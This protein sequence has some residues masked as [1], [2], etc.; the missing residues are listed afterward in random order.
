MKLTLDPD[1]FDACPQYNDWL[2]QQYIDQSGTLDILGFQPRPS[3]VLFSLSQDTYQAA[4]ADFQQQR[5]EELKQAIFYDFPSPI[6]HYFYRFENGYENELQRLHFLRDTWEAIID[7]LHATTIAECRFRC[8]PLA[9]PISFSHILSDSVAQR[10]LNIERI[11][12]CACTQDIALGISEMVS[13]STLETMRDLN[14]T[15]NAFS[16]S[17]GQSASQAQ[18]WIGECYEEVIDV[19]DDLQDMTNIEI[20][21]YLGQVAA[22]TLQCEVFRGHSFTRTIHNIQLNA[23]MVRDS[24]RYFQQGQVLILCS[25]CLFSLRP[26]IHYREDTSGHTTKLCMFRKKR[27]DATNR[28]IEYEVVGEA[29]RW[30]QDRNLF[31]PELDEL[32]ALFGLEPD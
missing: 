24:Q 32:R 23:D 18:M 28:R 17:A 13:I 12:N 25:G 6:A 16:H 9:H 27:G 31:K 5:Q 3:F 29:T 22:N 11:F 19:L 21:R 1:N 20:L 2:D 4:F 10:L 30:E 15:R 26:L 8:I 7:V 14:R